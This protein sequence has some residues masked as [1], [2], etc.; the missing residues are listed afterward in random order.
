MPRRVDHEERRRQITDAVVRIT[1]RG[2]L[3]AAT[4]REVAAE[5]GT[6]VRS[7]QYYF[8]SKDE[9]LLVTQRHVAER[10]TARLVRFVRRAEGQ[11]PREVLRAAL[12]SFIP[13]DR[14]SREAMLMF[15]ALHTASLLDP[16]LARTEARDVPRALHDLVVRQLGRGRLRAGVDPRHEAT[17]LA[18]AVPSL[19]QA[20]LDGTTTA[21]SATRTLE[22]AI[23]RVF[24]R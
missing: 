6:S 18:A 7:I 5:A 3:P 24:R 10:A 11:G 4:F 15:V 19:A 23:D 14:E 2:G 17:L 20:V 1:V 13:T 21:A 16:T 12:T 22:Y 9:L 8:G